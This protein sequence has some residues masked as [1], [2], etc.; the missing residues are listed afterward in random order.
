M[1]KILIICGPTATGKTKLAVQLA[2]QFSGEL[3]SADSRQVYQGM[4]I[5]TG[6]DKPK[7]VK[8]H[9]LDLVKPDEEFSVAHFVKLTRTL[10]NQISFPIIVG[11]T[12]L[13]LDSLIKPPSTIFAKPNWK[14]REKLSFFSIPKLL[15][16]LKQLNPKRLMQMNHS[17]QLNPRRLIRAIEVAIQKGP[18]FLSKGLDLKENNLLWIGLTAEKKILDQRI[19]KRV[20][21]RIKSGAIQEWQKLKKQY[22]SNLPSMSAIGYHQLP[23]VNKWIVAEQQYARRQLTWFKKNKA[24][25]WFDIDAKDLFKLVARQVKAWYTKK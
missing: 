24:I 11:G 20:E 10:I 2:K 7:G 8:I 25:R 16:L 6:K 5:V 3:I 4:D 19:K 21:Q 13:Y 22:G 9:G 14:L 1:T 12:G 23:D 17:D 15:K 18:T